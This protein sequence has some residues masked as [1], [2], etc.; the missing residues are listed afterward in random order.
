[1]A[2]WKQG[3]RRVL[4]PA[5]EARVV[6]RLPPERIPP[7]A[8]VEMEAKKAAGYY[9]GQAADPEA[10]HRTRGRPLGEM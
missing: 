10:V 4:Y 2:G 9:A 6:R 3:L 8:S 5:Y 7:D 1:M